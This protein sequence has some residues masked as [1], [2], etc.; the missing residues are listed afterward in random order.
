MS[1]TQLSLTSETAAEASP[2]A[3]CTVA[4]PPLDGEFIYQYSIANHDHLAV[5]DV[6]EVPLGRRTAIAFITSCKSEKETKTAQEMESRRISIRSISKETPSQRAFTPEHLAFYEWIAR[7]YAEPL[8]KILDLAIPTPAVTKPQPGYRLSASA[9]NCST[10]EISLGPIQVRVTEF[11]RNSREPVLASKLKT[12]CGASLATLRSLAQK[13]LIERVLM[14]SADTSFTPPDLTTV[15]PPALNQEQQQAIA[16][17]NEL[18]AGFSA[19]LLQ[20]VT[21]SGKTEIY[22]TLILEAL[23]KG[24]SALVIVPEIALTPQ[25]TER[26]ISRLQLPVAVLHS[27]LKPKERWRHWSDLVSGRVRVA[28]GARSAIFAPLHKLGLIV[29][30]EEHDS[31]FKQCVLN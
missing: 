6:I 1:S 25:L 22:L 2:R 23:T 18:G 28:I 31:S 8:S 27:S 24:L 14:A 26:F 11:L 29:V 5:G 7:Y 4:I 9:Q 16:S 15:T 3:F 10:N 13:N 17:I 30:D 20:G 21:G 19:T 12:E